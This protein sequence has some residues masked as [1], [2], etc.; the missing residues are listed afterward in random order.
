MFVKMTSL[1]GKYAIA[2]LKS[3]NYDNAYM[4]RQYQTFENCDIKNDFNVRFIHNNNE[5]TT[6]MSQF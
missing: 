2:K 4:N 6:R 5:A 1:L 3:I